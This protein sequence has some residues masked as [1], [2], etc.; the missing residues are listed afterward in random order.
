VPAGT[1]A[2]III[3]AL[4]LIFDGFN[5]QATAYAAPLIR[6]EWCLDPKSI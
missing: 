4:R 6:V 5:Y 3:A 1:P 2:F